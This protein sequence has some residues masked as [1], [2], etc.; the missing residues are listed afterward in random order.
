ML[1][2]R[3]IGT[4]WRGRLPGGHNATRG[5]ERRATAQP[6]RGRL[7]GVRLF[8]L[9][10][11]LML[12]LAACDRPGSPTVEATTVA[13][14][15]PTA[16]SN[17]AFLARH[18][19]RPLAPQFA[20]AA[21]SGA[22]SALATLDPAAC[23]TCHAAQHADWRGSLH[24]RAMGPGVAGQ[25]VTLAADDPAAAESCIRCHAPLAEQA[26]A[27]ATS[28]STD[29][30]PGQD[31]AVRLDEHGLLCAGCHLRA[32]K[33]YGPLRR[34]GSAPAGDTA[35]W[36]HQGWTG[37]RAFEDANFCAPCHQFEPGDYALN[38]KL[39]ENTVEEWKSSRHAREGR[40]CQACHMPDRRHL[41]RGIHDPE[42]V[43]RAV[44]IELPGV[45]AAGGRLTAE[46]RVRN[47]GA[48]HYFPTYVTPRVFAEADQQDAAGRTLPGT[49]RRY[50]ISRQVSPDLAREIADTRI[51]PGAQAVFTYRAPRAGGA[52][53]LTFRLRVEP[54]AFYRNLYQ[55]LLDDGTAGAGEAQIRRALQAASNSAFVAYT[56]RLALVDGRA[57]A[58]APGSAAAR[59]GRRPPPP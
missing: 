3:S 54:D 59:Q 8:A 17:A 21:G 45:Q 46:M 30:P 52:V 50:E 25:L 36:P 16:S 4:A 51:A 39:L 38:G 58:L 55:G 35:A 37:A 33:V 41:W 43:R 12:G 22:P 27:L 42:M 40:T 7:D 18:W 32:G 23:G 49:L 56:Q 5:V 20:A 11:L 26:D 48:G 31:A 10:S 57:D 15:A 34:D 6:L 13:A 53:A 14:P 28:L 29:V 47:D 2:Q 44:T 24:S 9:A 19:A 1:C